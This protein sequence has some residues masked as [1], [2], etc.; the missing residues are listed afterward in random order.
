MSKEK[1]ESRPKTGSWRP[2]RPAGMSDGT[3]KTILLLHRYP[4]EEMSE[5]DYNKEP[6]KHADMTTI[7]LQG[8]LDSVKAVM[9]TLACACD[10]S[11]TT[12]LERLKEI[13]DSE[14]LYE[15]YE[16]KYPELSQSSLDKLIAADYDEAAKQLAS[17]LE[18]A[19]SS[20]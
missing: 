12:W 1:N 20:K 18:N 9:E 15:K 13:K 2:F 19:K 4:T 16:K 17:S 11:D 7:M 6:E 3:W 10:T 8:N 5:E 14:G